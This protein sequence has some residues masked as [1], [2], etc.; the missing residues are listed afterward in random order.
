MRLIFNCHSG[1]LHRN[2]RLLALLKNFIATRSLD[3][4]LLITE[5]P[6]H[7]TVLAREAVRL[8]C[9]R[10]VAIGGDGTV[11]EVAQALRSTP[12]VLAIVPTGSGNGLARHLGLP[13][14]AAAA[15]ELATAANVRVAD[16]AA[17]TA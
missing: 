17:S 9:D 3:A 16:L 10:V 13:A 14:A 8:G 5:R 2:A 11:N 15:L 6:G 1:R 7:A 12:A 4:E